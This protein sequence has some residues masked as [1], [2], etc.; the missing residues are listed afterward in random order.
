MNN[1]YL[2]ICNTPYHI[3]ITTLKALISDANNEISIALDGE[4]P[5][6]DFYLSRLQSSNLFKE[7]FKL[8][9]FSR[10]CNN[11]MKFYSGY[12]Y[13]L[14]HKKQISNEYKYLTQFDEVYLFNDYSRPASIIHAMNIQY[15]LL[16]DGLNCFQIFDQTYMDPGIR[17]QGSANAKQSIKKLLHKIFKLPFGMAQ[18]DGCIDVEVNDGTDLSLI[19]GKPVI[20]VPRNSLIKQTISECNINI[21]RNIFDFPEIKRNIQSML[22][23]TQPNIDELGALQNGETQSQYYSRVMKSFSSEI[24]WYLKP[25]PADNCDYSGIIAKENIIKKE[26]PIEV[27]N[28]CG[29]T[30]YGAITFSSTSIA[31]LECCKKKYILDQ[32]TNIPGVINISI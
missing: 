17:A 30:L 14:R 4:I 20:E 19:A 18:F 16:E 9:A 3:Y 8:S 10:H 2:Y 32:H 21:M 12:I 31:A 23:L 22:L 11:N 7:V 15:H 13:A 1:R 27:L 29:T 26:I 6:Y 24:T 25:H 5:G 28:Y